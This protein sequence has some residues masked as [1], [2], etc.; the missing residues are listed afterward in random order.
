MCNLSY[1]IEENVKE[2]GREEGIELERMR[3][4]QRLLIKKFSKEE[5]KN[6]LEVTDE[7]VD[8]AEEMMCVK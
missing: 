5:V 7:E 3:S 4:I 8:A 1:G 6:L 2:E